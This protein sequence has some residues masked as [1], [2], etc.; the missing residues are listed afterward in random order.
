MLI[1][2]ILGAFSNSPPTTAC[3]IFLDSLTAF[4]SC[5][6]MTSTSICCLAGSA[7]WNRCATSPHVSS[8]SCQY[9]AHARES[10]PVSIFETSS[11]EATRIELSSN[12]Q[13]LQRCS[14]Y[15]ESVAECLFLL[16]I[17]TE[18]QV[19]QLAVHSENA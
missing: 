4:Q 15:S 7:A 1:A 5:C 6:W 2:Q 17:C 13:H 11:V 18:C 10:R 3:V 16:G 19:F 14:R 12:L 9:A 8:S